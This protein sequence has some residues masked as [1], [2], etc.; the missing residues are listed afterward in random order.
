MQKRAHSILTIESPQLKKQRP[1]GMR[2]IAGVLLV[3][4]VTMVLHGN[5][6]LAL[7]LIVGGSG[8]WWLLATIRRWRERD[9]ILQE[10]VRLSDHSFLTYTADL[11][12]AQGYGVLKVGQAGDAHGNLLL[13]HGDRSIACRVLRDGHYLGKSAMERILARM[14]LYGC[15][16]SMVVTDRVVTWSATRFAQRVGCIV[17]DR[18]ELIRLVGQ[19]R[20]GHRVYTFQRQE[21]A[22]LRRRK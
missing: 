17:I 15:K 20:Q 3:V 11:L 10:I 9:V 8:V 1:W 22:K 6:R 2:A 18:D 5:W 7:T 13:L 14:K 21:A 12:R 16:G 19:Y 4:F